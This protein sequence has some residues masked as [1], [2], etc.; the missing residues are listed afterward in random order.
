MANYNISGELLYYYY[1][2]IAYK[3]HVKDFVIHPSN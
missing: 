2:L 3:G 1:Y